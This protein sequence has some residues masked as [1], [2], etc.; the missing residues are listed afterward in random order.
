M[1]PVEVYLFID[2]RRERLIE[3]WLPYFP[4]PVCDVSLYISCDGLIFWQ[5]SAQSGPH[6]LPSLNQS[7][8]V[9]PNIKPEKFGCRYCTV[10]WTTD[11]VHKKC[12]VQWSVFARL[13]L[14]L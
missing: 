4:C 5:V 12:G 1:Q 7:R 14:D 9:L 8:N 2:L 3:P 13:D 10:H 6:A 11:S